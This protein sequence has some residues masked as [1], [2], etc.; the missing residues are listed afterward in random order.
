MLYLFL[1]LLVLCHSLQIKRLCSG[2]SFTL[3]VGHSVDLAFV[4]LKYGVSCFQPCNFRNF[5]L[6]SIFKRMALSV[7]KFLWDMVGTIF[8]YFM[9][10]SF[11]IFWSIYL[12]RAFWF[13]GVFQRVIVRCW[14]VNVLPFLKLF[15]HM[16][17]LV[18]FL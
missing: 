2:I 4:T 8:L 18:H 3:K 12:W 16:S 9:C 15:L 14:V 13:L 6:R 5:F 11:P 1:V 7:V 17:L 10:L